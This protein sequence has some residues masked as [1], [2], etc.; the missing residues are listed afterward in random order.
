MSTSN[1]IA[2]FRKFPRELFRVNNGPLVKVRVWTPE[3]EKYD[4]FA[5]KNL[6]HPKALNPSTY[7]APNGASMRPNSPYQQFLVSR[8]YR[9]LDTIVYSVP[10]GTKLPEDL[11]LVHE[12]W[13]H[14]SL[15]PAVVMNVTE[16]DEKITR[17]LLV[18]AKVFTRR[19]WL[20]A[21][22]EATEA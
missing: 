10:A 21:Y 19:Q 12:R 13:D 14:Y 20:E 1:L 15:Q 11:V 6:V 8:R 4:I 7:K 22:P 17:F 5:E 9:G 16:L 2:V 18:H 3:R